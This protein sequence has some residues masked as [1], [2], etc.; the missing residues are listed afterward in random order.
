[1][2]EPRRKREI[3]V[4]ATK[5]RYTV[6]KNLYHSSTFAE[7]AVEP[8]AIAPVKNITTNSKKIVYITHQLNTNEIYFSSNEP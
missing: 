7:Q 8:A 1:M 5:K 6:D 2:Q 3:D 4:Q